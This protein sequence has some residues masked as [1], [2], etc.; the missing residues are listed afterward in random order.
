MSHQQNSGLWG[1]FINAT[2]QNDYKDISLNQDLFNRM[3]VPACFQ[4]CARTD[5]DV[6]FLNEME[7][8]YKCMITYK[9]AFH[10]LKDLD[11]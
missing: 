2:S 1:N 4:Q 5:I 11:L 9:Q 10:H 3:V 6:V 8:S 7:C